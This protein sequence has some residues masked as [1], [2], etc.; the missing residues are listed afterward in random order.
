M[1]VWE[2]VR[3]GNKKEST[4]DFSYK[5]EQLADLLRHDDHKLRTF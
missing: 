1:R 3:W 5:L 2:E 4:V